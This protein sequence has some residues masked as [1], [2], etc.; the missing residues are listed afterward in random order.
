MRKFCQYVINN[1]SV[2]I[3]RTTELSF[4]QEAD[5]AAVLNKDIPVRME[6]FA[7]AFDE[8]GS[9]PLSHKA[10]GRISGQG[11]CEGERENRYAE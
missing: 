11:L 8:F 7:D 9:C 2:R 1:L 3:V 4:H 5:I 10:Q 6:L